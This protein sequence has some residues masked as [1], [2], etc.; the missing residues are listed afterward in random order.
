MKQKNWTFFV[1]LVRYY[2]WLSLSVTVS[3]VILFVGFACK[4]E[5]DPVAQTQEISQYIKG[6]NYD[7]NA[8]LNV[9]SIDGGS[10]KTQTNSTTNKELQNNNLIVCQEVAYNLKQNAEQV[11][12]IRPTNGIIWPGALVKVNEGLLNGMPEPV[13]LKSAPT[14]LRIDLPGMGAKGTIIVNEPSNSNTQTEID[15]AL[16]WWNNNQYVEGYVNASNS[17]YR[18]ATSFSSQQLALDLGLNV[19]W[20][21]GSV[22]AQFSYTSSSTSKVAMMTFK[23]V[24][25]TVTFDTPSQPGAVFDPSVNT[26]QIKSEFSN[27][28]P[29]GYVHSV[30]YGRIIMFRMVTTESATTSEVEGAMKYSTGVTTVSASLE[31]KYKSILQNSSIEVVTIGGNADTASQAVT[32]Q[33]FGDLESILT[34]KN[35]VYSKSNPGVPIAYT[36]KFL[37]DNKVAKMGYTTDYT[38]KE[39]STSKMGRIKVYGPGWYIAKFSVSYNN[40]E[41]TPVSWSSGNITA[42]TS[43]MYVIPGGS[44]NIVV[45]ASSVSCSTIFTKYYDTPRDACFTTGGT[46]CFTNYSEVQCDF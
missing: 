45:Q 30:S 44:T 36:V 19:K 7:P 34:G 8:I 10:L 42:G 40:W 33:N 25:Y 46:V 32:A 3:I 4:K 5:F 14:T 9:Q 17:S 28:E 16:D 13:T 43:K 15:K 6:L 1:L 11:A 18:A 2:R 27:A 23:Q 20:A 26:G 31:A 39:C 24:F 38:A 12:I 41:G 29:P 22:S 35:A 21:S 37:M